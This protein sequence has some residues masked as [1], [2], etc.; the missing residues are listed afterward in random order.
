[1][2][3]LGELL[4]TSSG[5]DGEEVERLL[6]EFGWTRMHDELVSGIG[7][8]G[9]CV[10]RQRGEA[11]EKGSK[12]GQREAIQRRAMSL[13]GD[14]RGRALRLSDDTGSQGFGGRLLGIVVEHR[15]EAL[16]QMP[17]DV[18]GEHAQRDV[19]AHARRRPLEDRSNLQIDDLDAPNNAFHLGETLAAR[20]VALSSAIGNLKV[21]ADHVGAVEASLGVD[22]ILLAS[23]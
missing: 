14:G 17:L 15:G 11:S 16:A 9:D 18:I 8:C 22:R 19:S 12:A 10:S 1:L 7:Y 6:Q 21:G 3:K 23:E 20:T 4:G 13:F 5:I 2:A